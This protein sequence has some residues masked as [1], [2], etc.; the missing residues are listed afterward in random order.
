MTLERPDV[1]EHGRSWPLADWDRM[2]HPSMWRRTP[3]APHSA[4]LVQIGAIL[5]LALYAN[6]IA[7]EVLSPPWYVPF[8]L[9]VLAFAVLMARTVGTTW[10][11]MGMRPDRARR[12]LMVGGLIALGIVI[13]FVVLVAIPGT[14]TAFEDD[15]IVEGSIGLSLYHAFIR[16]PLGTALYEEILFRGVLF[17]MLARRFKPLAS[18]VWSSLAFGLWHVLPSLDAIQANPIGDAVGGGIGVVV[19]VAGT[20]VAGM[21][22]VWIRLFGQSVVAPILV[23]IATNSI[24]ILAATFVVHVL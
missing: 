7:N 19:A 9:G 24:A 18:A 12:G 14:R 23:H 4:H 21:M 22:F 2:W 1:I 10:T 8:N 5:L 13:G 17:G 3:P 15:R 20:F 16:I 6:V 11:S